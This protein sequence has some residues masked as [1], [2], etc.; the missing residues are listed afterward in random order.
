[1]VAAHPSRKDGQPFRT[2]RVM[3]WAGDQ[4]QGSHDEALYAFGELALFTL[5]WRTMDFKD[6][7]VDR[8]STCFEGPASRAAAAFKQPSVNECPDCFGSTF[9]GGFRAQIVRPTI[10]AD[11]DAEVTDQARGV[12]RLDTLR[13][14][15]TSDFTLHKGDYIFRYDNTRFQCEEKDEGVVRT[16]FGPPNRADSFVGSSTGH[17]EEE[18]SVAYRI[19]PDPATLDAMLDIDGSF[20]VSVITALDVVRPG[21]YIL[22]A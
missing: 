17:L 3:E 16:G 5:M 14:E 15:T 8:C 19:P 7:L 4:V 1:M 21:G 11:R 2:E 12:V 18:T 9:E 22:D 6:G 13:F 10:V 20:T